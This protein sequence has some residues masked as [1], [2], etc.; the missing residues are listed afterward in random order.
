MW[1]AVATV[2]TANGTE[3][4]V[5][6]IFPRTDEEWT[7]VRHGAITLVEAANLLV[8]PGR[9]VARPGEKSEFP[10]IELEPEE[11]EVLINDGREAWNR[12]AAALHDASLAAL[13]AIDAKDPDTLLEVGGEI[14]M[15][16]ESCHTRYWYP[17]Q[18]L[19]REVLIMVK[20]HVLHSMTVAL[21]AV[22]LASGY[23][24]AA[25]QS[26]NL[27]TIKG[28]VGLTGER[29]GNVVIRMGVDPMCRAINAGKR[30]LQETVVTSADGSLANVFVRLEGSFP[31]T[32][33]P[34]EPVVIDQ[35]GCIY[36]PRVVGVRVGQTL[37][38][39]NS[40]ALLHN[41]H[42]LSTHSNG[43][44]VGPASGGHGESISAERRRTHVAAHV[45]HT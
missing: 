8:M 2:I 12:G 38:I 18:V 34:T 39:R 5:E 7:N 11:M 3:Q 31:E 15:A 42:S 36:G 22:A 26:A 23:V 33:V 17:N 43:F 32:P 19:P 29:P 16:C 25:A 1:Q 14:E 40:D 28:R 10:G 21:V 24:S 44:N 9:R 45:R 41:V 37:L 6:E 35:R 20:G 30:V 13:Q 27:G 4:I